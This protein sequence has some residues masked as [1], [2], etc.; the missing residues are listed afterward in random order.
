MMVQDDLEPG[1]WSKHSPDI[2]AM[3]HGIPADALL[4]DLLSDQRE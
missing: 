4:L 2:D 3:G 1:P